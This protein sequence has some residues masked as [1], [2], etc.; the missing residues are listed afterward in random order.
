MNEEIDILPLDSL[1]FSVL[2]SPRPHNQALLSV[3]RRANDLVPGVSSGFNIST[4]RS[5]IR[6]SIEAYVC[7]KV[8]NT[9]IFQTAWRLFDIFSLDISNTISWLTIKD[10]EMGY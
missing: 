1:Y 10:S 7:I 2:S 6:A 8:R 4:H 3:A 9:P 5:H